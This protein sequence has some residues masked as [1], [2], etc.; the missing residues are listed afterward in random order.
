MS[1]IIL[2]VF[3]YVCVCVCVCVC[4]CV[5]VCVYIYIYRYIM[6]SMIQ[7]VCL[8]PKIL[9]SKCPPI[10]TTKTHYSERLL[11]TYTINRNNPC[12]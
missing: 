7:L 5:C 8:L 2:L 11:R 10:I 4:I 6:P 12:S 9:K 3:L 1:S